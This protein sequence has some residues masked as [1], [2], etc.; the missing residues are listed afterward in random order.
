ME[1]WQHE[2]APKGGGD[3]AEH[4]PRSKVPKFQ[5]QARRK[6]VSVLPPLPLAPLVDPTS[7]EALVFS[8]HG[9]DSRQIGLFFIFNFLTS[10]FFH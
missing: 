7:I 2:T 3:S 10:F 5:M 4:R 8:R 9:F 6:S 1:V